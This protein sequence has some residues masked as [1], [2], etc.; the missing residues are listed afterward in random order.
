M[1]YK[2]EFIEI[3]T[4]LIHRTGADKLLDWLIDHSNFFQDPASTKYHLDRPEGLVEHS[5]NVYKRLKWLCEVESARNPKFRENCPSEE[6]IA[7]VGLLHDL[8]KADTYK[9][10]PKNFKNYDV[11]AVAAADSWQV[12]HDSGGDFVWDTRMEY[13]KDDPFPFG[14]GEK[15]VYIINQYMKLTEQEAMAIRFHMASWN[16]NEKNDAGRWFEK[17][18]FAFLTH[19]ADECA[20]FVDEV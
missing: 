19:V 15:S 13:V 18:T 12:K 3:F 5:I 9:K 14:H 2:E 6:T 1:S 20:T 4:K 17:D 7:I 8:C 16:E 10:S 11:S